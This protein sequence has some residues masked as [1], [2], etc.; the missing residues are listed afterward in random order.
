MFSPFCRFCFHHMYLSS[1]LQLPKSVVFTLIKCMLQSHPLLQ[2]LQVTS[3]VYI[4]KNTVSISFRCIVL[5]KNTFF[6]LPDVYFQN[7]VSVFKNCSLILSDFVVRLK[8][9]IFL[10]HYFYLSLFWALKII[11]SLRTAYNANVSKDSGSA[12]LKALNSL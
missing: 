2:A 8:A 3:D 10:V 11:I 7:H 9:S 4:L 5:H 12:F 6:L 1:A